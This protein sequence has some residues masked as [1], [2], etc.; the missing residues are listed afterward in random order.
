MRSL[1]KKEYIQVSY[2]EKKLPRTSYPLALANHLVSK[3]LKKPGTILDVGCGRGEYLEAFQALGFKIAG[4][5]LSPSVETLQSNFDVKKCD[6]EN[7]KLPYKDGSFDFIFSKSV[8]E[9]LHYPEMMLDECY[10]VL[11]PGGIAIIMCPSWIHTYWGPFYID[12][13][14]VT[15]FTRPSLEQVL[16]LAG[17]QQIEVEHFI[18]LPLVWKIPG[19]RYLCDFL[20]LLPLPFA[21]L[22]KINLPNSINKII[23]FSNEKMLLAVARK[24]K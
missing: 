2:D 24:V 15:P 7:E 13:T 3:F 5:D 8:I 16:S 10:R 18:Q 22:Y 12:H 4:V 14:H 17:F 6:F 11:R 9:H 21:P 1:E 23:R 19:L 20:A